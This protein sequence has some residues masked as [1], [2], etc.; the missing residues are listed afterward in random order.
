MY[1]QNKKGVLNMTYED[2]LRA[3]E[4]LERIKALKG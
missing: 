3:E 2:V 1:L 4:V